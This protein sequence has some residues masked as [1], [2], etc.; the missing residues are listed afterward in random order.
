MK[1]YNIKPLEWEE[2]KDGLFEAQS[3]DYSYEVAD[4]EK[5]PPTSH[6]GRRFLTPPAKGF[7]AT[8]RDM[9][10][11]FH[12]TSTEAKAACEAEQRERLEAELVQSSDSGSSE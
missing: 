3:G 12:D 6:D 2:R 4:N 5:F 8:G 1:T 11:S 9:E 7:G 10:S